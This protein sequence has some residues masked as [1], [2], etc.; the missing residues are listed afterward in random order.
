MHSQPIRKPAHYKHSIKCK[1]QKQEEVEY[2]KAHKA[3]MVT[4]GEPYVKHTPQPSMP[5]TDHSKTPSTRT[6][7]GQ[8]KSQIQRMA[9]H[10]SSST[11]VVS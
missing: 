6:T 4:M 7:M 8:G 10:A 3:C 1:T 2:P 11:G 9:G 5:C